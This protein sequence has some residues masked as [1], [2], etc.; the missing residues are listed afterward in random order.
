MLKLKKLF[1]VSFLLLMLVASSGCID[2]FFNPPEPPPGDIVPP[3]GEP[4]DLSS[5]DFDEKAVTI[6]ALLSFNGIDESLVKVTS[7]EVLV[8]YNQP[9]VKSEDDAFLHIGLILGTS[10]VV[11]QDSERIRIQTFIDELPVSE[12]TV[13][14][15]DFF[16]YREGEMNMDLFIKSWE[17][18]ELPYEE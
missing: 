11:H 4:P 7:D 18:K 3:P 9:P 8:R 5:G 2:D 15:S 16:A 12:I 6:Q 13:K 14:T 1:F 10:A 17:L